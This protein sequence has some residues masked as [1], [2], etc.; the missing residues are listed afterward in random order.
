MGQ[1]HPVRAPWN[2]LRN[3]STGCNVF[4][5]RRHQYELIKRQAF[6]QPRVPP[7]DRDVLTGVAAT[8]RLMLGVEP[9][10][11]TLGFKRELNEYLADVAKL[12]EIG[13]TGVNTDTVRYVLN[14]GV[15]Q[16]RSY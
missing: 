7:G 6:Y 11:F 16:Q 3:A 12:H 15:V 13:G 5:S 2:R 14:T 1:A 8:D 9:D 10:K 4:P